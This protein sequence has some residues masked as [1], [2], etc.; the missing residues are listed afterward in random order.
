MAAVFTKEPTSHTT[1]LN[2]ISSQSHYRTSVTERAILNCPKLD[3]T[4]ENV[5]YQHF[6]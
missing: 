3:R 5:I 2:C 1:T 4:S 6:A